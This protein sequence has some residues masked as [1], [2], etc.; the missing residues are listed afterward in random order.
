MNTSNCDEQLKSLICL[1]F[2]FFILFSTN[3][4]EKTGTF[5]EVINGNVGDDDLLC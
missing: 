3:S 2:F 5:E 4:S 1:L